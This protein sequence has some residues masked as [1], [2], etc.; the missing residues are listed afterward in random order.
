MSTN[1]A[2]SGG[3]NA[4]ND[5]Q[6]SV[7]IT[8]CTDKV[9]RLY[10]MDS[11]QDPDVFERVTTTARKDPG[12]VAEADV[13][14]PSIRLTGQHRGIISSVVQLQEP[15]NDLFLTGCSDGM[16][17]MFSL[18]ALGTEDKEEALCEFD[19]GRSGV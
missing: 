17:R 10:A 1:G 7:L 9:L 4:P 13:I 3:G 5:Q 8:G 11:P 15:T 16:V 12:F 2:S 6:S 14:K 19:Q 18:S